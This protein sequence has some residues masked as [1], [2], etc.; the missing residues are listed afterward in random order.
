MRT[1]IQNTNLVL[2]SDDDYNWTCNHSFEEL[3]AISKEESSKNIVLFDDE[4]WKSCRMAGFSNY[5]VS[6]YGRIKRLKEVQTKST[7]INDTLY[8]SI[9]PEKIL[10]GH[11]AED[12]YIYVTLKNDN[13]KY[14]P[15]LIAADSEEACRAIIQQVKNTLD[16]KVKTNR[17]TERL[18]W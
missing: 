12:G 7:G 9:V 8:T 18:I 3:A 15:I 1:Y 10:N 4:V 13:D 6:N 16:I 5:Q 2:L 14:G 17:G 11:L